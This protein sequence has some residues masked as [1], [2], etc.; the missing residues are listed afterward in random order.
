MSQYFPYQIFKWLKIVDIFNVN[1]INEESPI[2]C[3]LKVD[4]EYLDELNKLHNDY[5][6]AP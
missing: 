1:S 3:I 6:L 4:P 5:P 2:G